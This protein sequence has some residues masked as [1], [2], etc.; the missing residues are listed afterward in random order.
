MEKRMLTLPELAHYL[1][2]APQTI[3]NRLSSGDFPIMPTRK[4]CRKLLWDKKRVDQYLD[5]VGRMDS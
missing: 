4:L 3:K 1:G 5:R 2:L